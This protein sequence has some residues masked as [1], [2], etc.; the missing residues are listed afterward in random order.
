VDGGSDQRCINYVSIHSFEHSCGTAAL[1]ADTSC[2]VLVEFAPTQAGATTGSLTFNDGAGT[3]TVA[4][5]GTGG[6]CADGYSDSVVA[7]FS[8][9]FVGSLSAS[10]T[11]SLTN[12]GDET[13][14]A[15]G[16]SVSGPFQTSN[17]CGA[18]LTGHASCTISMVFAPTLS[19][20]SPAL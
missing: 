6:R 15:I 2:Q 19:E 3:Q 16:V 20:A 7:E 11:I 8:S 1:A 17:N 5:N 13:L 14:T 10:Q 9:D 12:S 4:L 18:Q